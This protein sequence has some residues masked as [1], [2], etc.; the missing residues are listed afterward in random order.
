MTTSRE[1]VDR[2]KSWNLTLRKEIPTVFLTGIVEFIQANSEDPLRYTWMQY[3]PRDITD[4]FWEP[5]QQR[6]L[7]LI[8]EKPVLE[9]RAGNLCL[10]DQ[11][12]L[13]SSRAMNRDGEPLFGRLSEYL[14]TKYLPQDHEILRIIGVKPYSPQ[15]VFRRLHSMPD[16]AI[17][18][19]P[20]SWHEDLAKFVQ[21]VHGD[22]EAQ[23]WNECLVLIKPKSLIPLQSGAW[24]SALDLQRS[25]VF[26]SEG[27][28]GGKIP[29]DINLRLVES[30]SPITPVQKAFFHL[31][32]VKDCDQSEVAR[33]IL[34]KH[35]D[36][37]P[38]LRAAAIS[39]AEYIYN[40]PGDTRE[41]LDI[42][43]LWLYDE[44]EVPAKGHE[45]YVHGKK[46][47]YS[48]SVLFQDSGLQLRFLSSDYGNTAIS[49]ARGRQF[50][51]WL[52]AQSGL[53]DCPKIENSGTLSPE[54]TFILK[55]R[56]DEVLHILKHY[57]HHYERKV[58]QSIRELI[59][60]HQVNALVNLSQSGNRSRKLTYLILS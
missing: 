15:V 4:S 54:F 53:S 23:I 18:S 57:W 48:I 47:K 7:Q 29:S 34:Q 44:Q 22:N 33:L 35:A 51:K 43:D 2:S 20:R 6:I 56:P 25:P 14:S 59:A 5:V 1:D 28:D 9:S 37:S 49:G 40:L 21:H 17:K 10:P 12:E 24:V 32:G 41:G 8:R 26:F 19:K 16:R 39:H 3:I 38:P 50:L 42:H 60:D 58:N 45:L 36:S 52:I 46:S 31:L 55:H 11:L 13:L 30:D 27:V